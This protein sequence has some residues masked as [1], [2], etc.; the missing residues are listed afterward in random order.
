[1]G[2]GRRTGRG[3]RGP[4]RPEG[5]DEWAQYGIGE[6]DADGVYP[7][8]RIPQHLKPPATQAAV[9]D[10]NDTV[11]FGW[12]H[13]LTNWDAVIWDLSAIHGIDLYDPAV[14]ARPWPGVCTLILGLV[15][16]PSSRL[17]RALIGG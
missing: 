14:R 15:D 17:H 3:G 2:S 5:L 1:M 4:K 11:R 9:A 7:D 13:I 10:D 16:E 6:P 8:Y 12:L